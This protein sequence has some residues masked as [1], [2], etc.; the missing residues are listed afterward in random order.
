MRKKIIEILRNIGYAVL[1][2]VL[3]VLILSYIKNKYGI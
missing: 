3:T 1:L 2:A